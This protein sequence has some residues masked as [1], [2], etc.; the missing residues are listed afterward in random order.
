M[1]VDAKK[2]I[3]ELCFEL[4]NSLSVGAEIISMDETIHEE[5]LIKAAD[6]L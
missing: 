4:I 6:L 1:T 3:D 5:D 2:F